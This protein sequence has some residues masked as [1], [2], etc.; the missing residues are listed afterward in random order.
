MPSA[1][2]L[3]SLFLAGSAHG[4]LAG[5]VASLT[6][7]RPFPPVGGDEEYHPRKTGPYHHGARALSFSLAMLAADAEG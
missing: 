1:R 3:A 6:I 2:V 5:V 7:L 4:M